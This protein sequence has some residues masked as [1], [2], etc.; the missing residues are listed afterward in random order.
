MQ[1]HVSLL[2]SKSVQKDEM[3]TKV[4]F[5]LRL[6]G[7]Q[8]DRKGNGGILRNHNARWAPAENGIFNMIQGQTFLKPCL[9]SLK[10]LTSGK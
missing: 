5:C 4:K 10:S 9:M 2:D 8:D 6:M 7:L 3:C 1:K